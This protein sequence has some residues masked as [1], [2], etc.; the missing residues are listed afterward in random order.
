MLRLLRRPPKIKYLE[1]ESAI[2]DGRVRIVSRDLVVRAKLTSSTGE[3]VYHVALRVE[4]SN[5][6]VYSDDNGTRLRGYVGYPILSVMILLGLLPRNEK[7]EEAL[8]GIPWKKL[9]EYYKKY[10]LVIEE[11]KKIASERGVSPEEIDNYMIIASR[12]LSRFRVYFD[13]S[14]ARS[15]LSEF[16]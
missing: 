2:G 11:V 14:L 12:A 15:S 4:D 8:K 9:N 1:A 6:S 3:K 16:I 13:D 7:I 10:D 5:I